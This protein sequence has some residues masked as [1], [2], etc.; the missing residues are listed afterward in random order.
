[1]SNSV[2][3]AIVVALGSLL[4]YA[5]YLS[6]NGQLSYDLLEQRVATYKEE[7]SDE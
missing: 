6:D 4:E 1:M 7:A 5:K 3:T 2:D